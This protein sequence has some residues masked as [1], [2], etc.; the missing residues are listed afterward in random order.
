MFNRM[1]AL[2]WL[3]NQVIISNKNLLV[4]VLM[5]Y[6]LLFLYKNFMNLDESRGLY[7]MFIC[8]STAIAMSVGS[9]VSTMIA[10]EKEKNNLKTLL[11][12][13]VRPLEYLFSVLLHP[14]LITFIN[15]ILFPILADAD[16]SKIYVEY[17]VVVLF[18]TVVV[19]LLNL[20]IAAV[21]ATQTKAQIN[22][23]P[24]MLIVAMGPIL[25]QMNGDVANFIQYTFL[26]A[27]TD[28]FTES[29]FSLNS[30]SFH[31]LIIWVL[32]LIAIT[33]IALRFNKHS[34]LKSELKKLRRVEKLEEKNT[35]GNL[36]SRIS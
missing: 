19:I 21:S 14:I 11:L 2:I 28:L 35:E 15:M 32:G 30:R 4:Q 22:G 33:F 18:T 16:I 7:L 20:Y 27:Y 34:K 3:R 12:N 31:V 8:L 9:T 10:E 25:S 6:G 23:L 1:K 5:P 13:G 17:G 24:I 36:Y 26:G 29:G